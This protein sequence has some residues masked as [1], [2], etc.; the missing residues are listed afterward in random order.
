MRISRTRGWVVTLALALPA[1]VAAPARAQS[2]STN[3]LST[4]N[5]FAAGG[6][7]PA[8]PAGGGAGTAPNL[9]ALNAGTGRVLTLGAGG[10]WNCF[11]GG[12]VSGPDGNGCAGGS[13][14]IN[15][16]GSIAGIQTAT[17]T[18][19]L[20][21]VF[22]DAGLPG[23]APSR[24]I[25]SAADLTNPSYGAPQLGQVFFLG[26]GLTGTGVG[27][28]QAFG[29]PDA[30]TRL[31]LG[32]ADAFGFNGDPGFYND[33]SGSVDV[34]YDIVASGVVPEPSSLA[35]AAGGLLALAGWG[36][37]RRSQR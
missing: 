13:T 9:I 26:D 18:M 27:S 23:A 34:R 36:A 3:V 17:Q 25:Y 5:I 8:A 15:S 30:A 37:R 33:N 2:G 7:A 14:N 21:G 31:F 20:V 11:G 35:L 24:L 1:V 19:F 6:N 4:A 12:P 32:V 28:T 10:S 16:T 22:L 29:V